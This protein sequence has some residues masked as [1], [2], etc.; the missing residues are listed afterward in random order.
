[1][2]PLLIE[3]FKTNN[4]KPTQDK[5]HFLFSGHKYGT[6]LTNVGEVE[7][8]EWKQQKILNVLIHGY[9]NFDE[10]VLSQCRKASE[11]HSALICKFMTF[12][13]SRNIMKV[14]IESPYCPLI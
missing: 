4:M 14:F 12:A 11:Q 9:L 13:Q 5:I 1:M 8:W 3:W 6:L 2:G 7:I 10:Y